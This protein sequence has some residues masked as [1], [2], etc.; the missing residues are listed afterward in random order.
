MLILPQDLCN[1]KQIELRRGRGLVRSAETFHEEFVR[2]E[3]AKAEWLAANL[4]P[5]H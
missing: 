1:G 5:F 3:F 4:G 2:G